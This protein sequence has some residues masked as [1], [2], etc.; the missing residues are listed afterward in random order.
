[1]ENLKIEV[2]E[3][4]TYWERMG[5]VFLW[6]FF[7]L[8]GFVLF[9]YIFVL[10][11]KNSD[12]NFLLGIIYIPFLILTIFESDFCCASYIHFIE[13]TENRVHI[14]G[15][16]RNRKFEINDSIEKFIFN[17][18]NTTGRIILFPSIKITYEGNV[19]R[20]ANKLNWKNE[21]AFDKLSDY[22]EK[23]K[24]LKYSSIY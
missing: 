11:G 18:R 21:K 8:T 2:E 16:K 17:Y 24:L 22:L 6:P 15:T 9:L 12:G 14:I 1:M 19:I 10:H 7:I 23:L 5:R 20:Q 13:I 4:K 3:T